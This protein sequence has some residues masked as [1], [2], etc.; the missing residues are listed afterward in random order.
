M[1][2]DEKTTRIG[3]VGLGDFIFYSLSDPSL[4]EGKRSAY[5]ARARNIRGKW[6]DDKY[7]PNA[8]AIAVLWAG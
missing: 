1:Y 2:V 5:L 8:M 4:A 7:S 3:A 6:S